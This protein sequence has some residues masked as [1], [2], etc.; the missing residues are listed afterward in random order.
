MFNI[1]R[2]IGSNEEFLVIG[3]YKNTL[4]YIMYFYAQLNKYEYNT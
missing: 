2:T 3:E 1:I 4:W